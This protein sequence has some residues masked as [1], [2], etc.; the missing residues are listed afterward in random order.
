MSW[1]PEADINRWLNVSSI[2]TDTFYQG[3]LG[4]KYTRQFQE[5]TNRIK[6]ESIYVMVNLSLSKSYIYKHTD[7]TVYSIKNYSNLY[8]MPVLGNKLMPLTFWKQFLLKSLPIGTTTERYGPPT[9]QK[10][11]F[12]H[13]NSKFALKIGFCPPKRNESSSNH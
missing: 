12:L 6:S 9:H 2:C 7:N 3:N 5:T 8:Q 10:P 13:T 1:Q 4:P 11:N